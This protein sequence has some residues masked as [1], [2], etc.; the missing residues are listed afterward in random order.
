MYFRYLSG[1]IPKLRCSVGVKGSQLLDEVQDRANRTHTGET[2]INQIHTGE[3]PTN[4]IQTGEKPQSCWICGVDFLHKHDLDRHMKLHTGEK[5]VKATC[6]MCGKGFY[7]TS[8]SEIERHLRTH[9]GE[10]PFKCE[11]CG[12]SFALKQTLKKHVLVIHKK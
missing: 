9:T 7:R 12:K 4:Q 8:K 6:H 11:I 10:K 1:N 3:K 5:P 2:P